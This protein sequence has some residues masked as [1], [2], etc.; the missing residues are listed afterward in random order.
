MVIHLIYYV[1][2]TKY[3]RLQ[4]VNYS[5]HVIT[6]IWTPNFSFHLSV[7]SYDL[8]NFIIVDFKKNVLF[9]NRSVL[10]PSLSLDYDFIISQRHMLGF[11][12]LFFFLVHIL[13]LTAL[14]FCLIIANVKD[15]IHPIMWRHFHFWVFGSPLN[16]SHSR[17]L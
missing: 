12:F 8:I 6:A 16:V 13:S 5:P 3:L 4:T 14:Y 1:N 9:L 7:K 15:R 10:W 11:F 17:F 2:T